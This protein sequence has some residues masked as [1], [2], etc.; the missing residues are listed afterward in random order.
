MP[1]PTKPIG[2]PKNK[3]GRP[4][5]PEPEMHGG[6]TAAKRFDAGLRFAIDGGVQPSE[7]AKR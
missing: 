2:K 4:K 3:G 7:K 1:K 6:E 5:K